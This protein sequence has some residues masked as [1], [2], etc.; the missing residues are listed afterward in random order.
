MSRPISRFELSH[1]WD[2]L[3]ARRMHDYPY[4]KPGDWLHPLEMLF[5]NAVCRVLGHSFYEGANGEYEA[6]VW[7]RGCRRCWTDR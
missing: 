4:A 2:D 5:R 6:M 1:A 3:R 7:K